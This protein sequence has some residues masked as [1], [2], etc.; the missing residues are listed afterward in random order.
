MGLL[1]SK[2]VEVLDLNKVSYKSYKT[3]SKQYSSVIM[4][5]DQTIKIEVPT[6]QKNCYFFVFRIIVNNI[7]ILVN[8]FGKHIIP[9][10]NGLII[11]NNC[12]CD[13]T[14]AG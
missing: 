3:I 6:I 11:A 10:H 2:L 5:V 13:Y 8:N 4:F 7:I 9:I 14:T 12:Y 1:H